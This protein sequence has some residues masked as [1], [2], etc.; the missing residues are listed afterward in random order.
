MV[1]ILASEY[2]CLFVLLNEIQNKSNRIYY[3][4]FKTKKICNLFWRVF[5]LKKGTIAVELVKCDTP[6]Q[7]REVLRMSHIWFA[8]FPFDSETEIKL[9]YFN[10]F[11]QNA[12][13]F[14]RTYSC[15]DVFNSNG[16][17]V[18]EMCTYHVVDQVVV[19]SFLDVYYYDPDSFFNFLSRF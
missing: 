6:M 3:F 9:L 4:L 17:T 14:F 15:L 12:K 18:Y 2:I 1:G 19:S 10:L 5:S 7:H 11:F 16:C 8:K 13:C